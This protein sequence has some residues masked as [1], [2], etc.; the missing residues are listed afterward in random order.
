LLE[1]C[2]KILFDQL[3]T[4]RFQQQEE[5]KQSGKVKGFHYMEVVTAAMLFV[6]DAGKEQVICE[7]Q[8]P[9]IR[10]KQLILLGDEH[11]TLNAVKVYFEA[12]IRQCSYDKVEEA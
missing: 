10:D 4:T 2:C 11:R 9:S 8:N 7:I 1:F 6:M 5:L 12:V 3:I